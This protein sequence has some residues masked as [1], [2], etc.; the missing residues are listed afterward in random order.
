MRKD[1][2]ETN[3]HF[4]EGEDTVFVFTCNTDLK[5]R[6][7]RYAAAYPDLCRQTDDDEMGG[8]CFEMDKH[9]FSI[10]L[11]APYSEERRKAASAYAKVK[12][13]TG[14]TK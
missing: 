12:G 11:T 8:L 14:R 13:L 6:L 9:R 1:L 7:K 3:I 5:K 2:K 10:R 4:T